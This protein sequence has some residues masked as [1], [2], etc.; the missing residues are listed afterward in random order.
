MLSRENLFPRIL[1]FCTFAA[2][3]SHL[4]SLK[5][6]LKADCQTRMF[7]SGKHCPSPIAWLDPFGA[8]LP[9]SA[10]P[11]LT[12]LIYWDCG[13]LRGSKALSPAETATPSAGS[14]QTQGHTSS[15]IRQNGIRTTSPSHFAFPRHP[16]SKAHKWAP[17]AARKTE[18]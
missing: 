17:D 7:L 2:A 16:C 9:I 1:R 12:T 8:C 3:L 6:P 4:R 14:G 18:S 10:T 15:Q 13:L 5:C 11:F